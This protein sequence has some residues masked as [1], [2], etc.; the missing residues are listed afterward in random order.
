MFYLCPSVVSI[1]SFFMAKIDAQTAGEAL[2]KLPD[3]FDAD[4][5]EQMSVE[6]AIQFVLSGEEP[7]EWVVRVKGRECTVEQGRADAPSVTILIDAA[8]WLSIARGEKSGKDAF[9]NGEYRVEGNVPFM[10]GFGKLFPVK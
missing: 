6:A 8:L 10:M 2:Q 7:S 5:S 3:I 1:E 9:M 4:F